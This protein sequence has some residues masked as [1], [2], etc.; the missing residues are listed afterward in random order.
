LEQLNTN[1]RGG[2]IS[3]P[4]PNAAKKRRINGPGKEILP[5]HQEMDDT[6]SWPGVTQGKVTPE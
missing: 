1:K 2:N 5:G 6:D 3:K 4:K